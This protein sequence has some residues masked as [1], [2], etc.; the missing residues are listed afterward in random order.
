MSRC[1]LKLF[2]ACEQIID[3]IVRPDFKERSKGALL[4]GQTVPNET[5]HTTF[6]QMDFGLCEDKDGNIYLDRFYI[7]KNTGQLIN[8]DNP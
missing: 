7:I 6:L 1:S 3:V 5:D 4:S 8:I 2:D